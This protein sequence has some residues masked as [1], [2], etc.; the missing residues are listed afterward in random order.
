MKKLI[1]VITISIILISGAKTTKAQN[2]DSVDVQAI[3]KIQMLAAQLKQLEQEQLLKNTNQNTGI[4]IPD[5][6]LIAGELNNSTEESTISN[7]I[8][9]VNEHSKKESKEATDSAGFFNI[10]EYITPFTLKMFV[11]FIVASVAAGFVIKRRLKIKKIS[12]RIKLKENVKAMREE[13]LVK[14]MDPRLKSIRKRLCLTSTYLNKPE[15]E[16]ILAAKRYQISKEEIYLASRL[17][18]YKMEE[19]LEARV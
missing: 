15:K 3:V 4:I 5:N 18:M 17:N 9:S 6:D 19:K 16:V 14:T 10:M 8:I 1:F 11:L 7:S 2:M 12:D 13:Q